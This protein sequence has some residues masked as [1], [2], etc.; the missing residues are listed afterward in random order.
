AG[1][2]ELDRLPG[3]GPGTARAVVQARDS[4]PFVSL[5]DLL[6]VRGIGPATLER[7]APHLEVGRVVGAVRA[8]SR[9]RASRGSA[10]GVAGSGGDGVDVNRATAE[11]L[12]ALPGVGPVLAG[13]IVDYRLSNGRF[14]G[15][16][17]LLPVPGIGPAL[18]EKMRSHLRF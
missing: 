8:A 16:E 6:R 18:L 13:R 15:P 5:Q 2:E 14:R 11:E 3:V 12:T 9:G 17:D 1:E 7:L 10:S 4:L